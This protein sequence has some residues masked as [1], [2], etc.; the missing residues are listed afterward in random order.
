MGAAP[1][2]QRLRAHMPAQQR[3]RSAFGSPQ[4]PF[5]V[6]LH[7]LATDTCALA[8]P[9]RSQQLAL[10]MIYRLHRQLF[11]E[12]IGEVVDDVEL[13]ARLAA[14]RVA[15]MHMAEDIRLVS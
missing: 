8:C 1:G 10:E 4:H 5:L 15:R 7:I 9:V 6:A 2:A 12:R 14:I 11:P 13:A 3:S